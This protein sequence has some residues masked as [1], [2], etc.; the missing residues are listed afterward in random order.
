ML[1]TGVSKGLI[2]L[3]LTVNTSINLFKTKM[4]N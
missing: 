4:Q 3:L 2:L 1:I